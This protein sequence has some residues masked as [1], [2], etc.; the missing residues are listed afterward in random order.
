MG[1]SSITQSETTGCNYF[2]TFTVSPI[3]AAFK[4]LLINDENPMLQHVLLL[5]FRNLRRHR[6]TFIINLIGLSTGLACVILIFSWVQDELQIDRFHENE[7]RL[8]QVMEHQA[9]AEGI[10]TTISTPG[11]LAETLKEEIP[12]ID[13]AFTL[14]WPNGYTLTYED[15]DISASGYDAGADFFHVFSYPLL[16]GNPDH[17]LS[18]I[19]SIVISEEV[20]IN[21]FGS[22]A[23]AVGKQIKLNQEDLHQ[24]SGVFANVDVQSSIQFDLLLN[25][26]KIKQEES[27]LRS[28]S[29]NG[30][31]TVVTLVEGA[32]SDAVSNKIADFVKERNEESNVTLF[33]HSY[34]DRYLHG[35]FKNGKP[36]GGRIEYVQLFTLIALFILIIACINF[37]NLSTARASRRA[38]EVGV[39]KTIGANRKILVGQFLGESLLV[40]MFSAAVAL[41]LAWL[42]IPRFNLITGKELSLQMSSPFVLS[43]LAIVF[44]TGLLAGSYPA[45]Y[46]SGFKPV[47]VLKGQLTTSLSEVWARR[48]LVVFQFALSVFL[49]VAVFVVY[50]QIQY[51]QTK[52]LGYEKD[53]LLF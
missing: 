42:F 3:R 40:T 21:L 28:W 27:W 39:K 48:G 49:I 36:A 2:K 1:V 6:S 41:F 45:L 11:M 37:M 4:E 10:M 5:A 46:L 15:R 17:V 9:Y 20:A 19:N 32:D 8:Y 47:S 14:T 43:Y 31:R 30:P 23:D 25:F 51:V 52:N 18:D 34:A 33:L 35:R 13:R 16:H 12:E 29:S 50:N 53:N 24:V 22:A 44:V 7:D 38:K 26:E